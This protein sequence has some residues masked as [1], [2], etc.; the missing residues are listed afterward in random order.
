MTNTIQSKN[1]L[2]TAAHRASRKAFSL[3]E[4]VLAIGIVSFAL[5][6]I[7]GLFGGLLKSSAENNQRRA[8]AEAIDALR[9]TLQTGNFHTNY[10]LISQN[11]TLLFVTYRER[12]GNPDSSS[13]SVLSRWLDPDS[14]S[15][16]DSYD[17]ARTGM[18]IRAKLKV[19]PGNPGGTSLPANPDDYLRAMVRAIVTLDSIPLPDK[20]LPPSPPILETEI[21]ALR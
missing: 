19:S 20:N 8:L 12:N 3:V 5:L 13:A 21:A 6:T 17:K 10:Q 14:T 1:P 9:R 2:T 4:V 15:D 7:I 16:L 18:W 11:K